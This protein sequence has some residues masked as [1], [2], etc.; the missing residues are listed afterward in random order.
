[1]KTVCLF[2]TASLAIGCNSKDDSA[3]DP[4]DWDDNRSNDTGHTYS[5]YWASDHFPL[6]PAV[7][8]YANESMEDFMEVSVLATERVSGT[9]V[10]TFQYVNVDEDNTLL[11]HIKWSSDSVNGIQ[12]HGYTLSDASW[13]NFSQPLQ[14]VE[15][16]SEPYASIGNTVD[17]HFYTSTFETY[18]ACPNLWTEN[19]NCM[20][21]VISSEEPNAA[22]FL[23]TWHWA[24]EYGTSL[25]KPEGAEHPWKLASHDWIPE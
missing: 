5:G 23:G 15:R 22:P 18:E 21:V 19:W 8:T 11:F 12:I 16:Q 6:T 25:F 9:E 2:L 17:G 24:T 4:S 10:A 20:K 14:I 7:W 13:V 3:S 1:M